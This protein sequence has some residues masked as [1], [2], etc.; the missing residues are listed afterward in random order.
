MSASMT[1]DEAA[2]RV[3]SFHSQELWMHVTY[4]NNQLHVAIDDYFRELG[5]MFALLPITTRM[6]SSPGAVYG[7]EKVNYT[8]DTCPV[9]VDWFDLPKH[10][11]L[12]ESAQIYLELMLL[13]QGIDKVYSF[14]NSFRKEVT[15]A[16]HLSEFHHVEFEGCVEHDENVDIA[17]LL[18]KR[19]IAEL[20][21]EVPKSIQFFLT[22]DQCN[23]LEILESK[24]PA[25]AKLTFEEAMRDLREATGDDRYSK[26]TLAHFGPWEEMMLTQ[27]HGSI[28]A[29][30]QPPLLE[31]PFYHRSIEVNGSLRAMNTDIIWPG[32][33]EIIGS[34][35]RIA[36]R[37]ELEEKAKIFSLPREDYAPYLQSRDLVGYRQTS[38]FG[39]GWERLLQGLLCAPFIWSCSAL[40][41]TDRFLVP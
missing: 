41:R 2:S 21:R 22:D 28:V 29:I 39:L 19:V 33:R 8:T 6:I 38:G 20:L 40:P 11:F 13:S 9:N 26:C 15:D 31:V 36:S 18:L 1:L 17:L 12:A 34:G 5:A 27:I 32:Y 35:E 3:S 14:Y 4:I 16:T 24:L 37:D 10:A 25:V 30:S 7:K 23:D